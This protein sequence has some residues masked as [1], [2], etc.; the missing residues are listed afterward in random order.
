MP[1]E[2]KK[3]DPVQ[4]VCEDASSFVNGISGRYDFFPAVLQL[5]KDGK[6]SVEL[7]KRFMLRAIDEAWV[8]A[9]EDA[10]PALDIIIRT[11]SKFIEEREQLMPIEMSHNI[12][13]RSLRHLAQ[14]TNLISKVEGDKITPS[15]I[16]NVFR[17]ETLQTYENK[18]I[19]TLINRLLI[20]VSRRYEIAKKAGMDEKTTSLTFRDSFR[21]GEA[22]ISMEMR[23]EISEPVTEGGEQVGRNYTYTTDLWKRVERLY[24]IVVTYSNSEFVQNMGQSYIRPPIMRTNA[25]MKNKNLR[26]CLALWQFIENYESAGYSMLVQE[27]LESVDEDYLKEL[28]SALALQYFIFRHNI[29]N[30]FDPEKTVASQMTETE[31]KPRVVDELTDLERTD[32]FDHTSEVYREEATEN[33]IP[34]P[35]MTRY[36]TLTPEDKL[37]LESLD[38]AL[39]AADLL[40]ELEPI[41]APIPEPEPNPPAPEEEEPKP[42]PES[43]IPAEETPTVPEAEAEGEKEGETAAEETPVEPEKEEEKEEIEEPLKDLPVRQLATGLSELLEGLREKD[44]RE[45]DPLADKVQS[46]LSIV[47]QSMPA[48][49]SE[50]LDPVRLARR[51]KAMKTAIKKMNPSKRKKKQ[52]NRKS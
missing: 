18:F 15:K 19:N 4:S 21:H 44:D 5:M 11:P 20:F 49:P 2:T 51:K 16:L 12:S 39:L 38:V 47:R 34:M 32:E 31:F 50:T 48:D 36:G 23:M 3:S 17:E 22:Q 29:Q 45:L 1:E 40:P 13:V 33:R 8:N 14:H 9:I 28:Y 26:Q 24:G 6:A 25:I 30:D 42:E 52:H 35:A 43:V 41:P 46:I 27:S 7:K 37:M 10:L